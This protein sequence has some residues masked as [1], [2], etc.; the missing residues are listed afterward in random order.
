MRITKVAFAFFSIGFLAGSFERAAGLADP[1]RGR[2]MTERLVDTTVVRSTKVA[3]AS[4]GSVGS[5]LPYELVNRP[6]AR[7]WPIWSTPWP[8]DCP[9]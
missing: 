8:R 6:V 1:E 7:C 3:L 9:S 5:G 4:F 2:R